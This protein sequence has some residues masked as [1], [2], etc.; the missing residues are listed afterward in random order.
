LAIPGEPGERSGGPGFPFYSSNQILLRSIIPK[1]TDPCD[2]GASYGLMVVNAA[3]GQA[4]V[5]PNDSSPS[6][7]V[8]GIV[9]SSTPPGDPVTVRGGG[10]VL[11]PG[12]PPCPPNTICDP[13]NPGA[14]ANQAIAA[15]ASNA[16]SIW[17]RA[18]WRELL[19]RM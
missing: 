7:I 13:A 18:S 16:D 8:G 19:D 2:P 14:N 4:T 1:G 9:R 3:N 10:Q 17:A 5:D 11:I 12:V 15:A 6:R